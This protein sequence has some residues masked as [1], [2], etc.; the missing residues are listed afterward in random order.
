MFE[1]LGPIATFLILAANLRNIETLTRAGSF[2]VIKLDRI[3]IYI[4]TYTCI[5]IYM[6][7]V[8]KYSYVTRPCPAL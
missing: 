4:Y 7:G 8:H 2:L 3:Y 5:Y 1:S 6:L